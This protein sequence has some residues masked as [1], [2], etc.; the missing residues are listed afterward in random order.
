[1]M[2]RGLA[3]FMVMTIMVASAAKSLYAQDESIVGSVDTPGTAYGVY[4]SGSYAY[5]AD[6]DKGLQVIDVGDTEM[7]AIVGSLA[8]QYSGRALCV[9]VS[10][11]YAYVVCDLS[12]YF[13]LEVIDISNHQTPVSVSY[14]GT[15][16]SPRDLCVSGHY[17]YVVWESS[18]TAGLE[19]G[20]Q[21]IDVSDPGNSSLASSTSTGQ[22]AQGVYV[23]GSYACVVDGG[24]SG[25]LVFDVS[26]PENPSSVG[27]INVPYAMKVYISGDY[28]YVAGADD[29]Q[30][31]D[32]RDPE[33][34][35]LVGS[36]EGSLGA[37][38]VHVSGGYAYV[39]A[40]ENGLQV[41][42]I[43]NPQS[44]SVAA[45]VDIPGNAIDVYVSG[46]YAYVA[47]SESGLQ[48]I[49][50]SSALTEEDG[51]DGGNGDTGDDSGTDEERGTCFFSTAA[52]DVY[53]ER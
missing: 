18:G 34:P 8:M 9:H 10:G 40:Y 51:G 38:S 6:D 53:M 3:V 45:S 19:G 32:L 22:G 47:A 11:D 48:V 33:N 7:P 1:M 20:L 49:D 43:S 28:A 44:P 29:F 12:G 50:I 30:V 4:V 17:A 2:K 42:N 41:I 39:A 31:F 52:V 5:V 23:S 35:V 15:Q 24:F 37:Q 46:F 16:G 13:S 27:S 26:D 25:L 36:T 21:I 14:F